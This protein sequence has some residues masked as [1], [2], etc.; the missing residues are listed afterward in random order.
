MYKYTIIH[1]RCIIGPNLFFSL[2]Q[3]KYVSIA[4]VQIKR[5]EELQ[6]CPMTLVGNMLHAVLFNAIK[7]PTS[8]QTPNEAAFLKD[9]FCECKEHR[10]I[11][12]V[13]LGSGRGGG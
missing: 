13:L 6:Q 1:Q 8:N 11:T 2:L 9:V 4:E 10:S 3:H 5:E 7:W 12:C